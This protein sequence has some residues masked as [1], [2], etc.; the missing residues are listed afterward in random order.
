MH[1]P[2]VLLFGLL[3][4]LSVT[5]DDYTDRFWFLRDYF[6]QSKR[7]SMNHGWSKIAF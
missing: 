1:Q 3:K 4:S 5:F 6:L 2:S 7:S